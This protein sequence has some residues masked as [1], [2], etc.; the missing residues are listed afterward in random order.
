MYVTSRLPIWHM[1]QVFWHTV[2]RTAARPDIKILHQNEGRCFTFMPQKWKSSIIFF[3]LV[4]FDVK[5]NESLQSTSRILAGFGRPSHCWTPPINLQYFPVG[6]TCSD[7]IECKSW[8]P[9]MP[10]LGKYHSSAGLILPH[11]LCEK[12]ALR[13]C[14][15]VSMHLQTYTQIK[16]D[17]INL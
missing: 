13:A 17:Q 3:S 1:V 2:T 12:H 7:E 9:W 5:L 16:W 6:L 15:N 14:A 8:F 10:A 11:H 4:D